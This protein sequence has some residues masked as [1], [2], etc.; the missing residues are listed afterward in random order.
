MNKNHRNEDGSYTWYITDEKGHSVPVTIPAGPLAD[1]ME[2]IDTRSN[3][4]D[5][6]WN[7]LIDWEFY[8]EAKEGEDSDGNMGISVNPMDA[9]VNPGQSVEEQVIGV[10]VV[11]SVAVVETRKAVSTLNQKL[12]D[13]YE[14][15]YETDWTQ[16]DAAK[17]LGKKRSTIAMREKSIQQIVKEQLGQ[18]GIDETIIVKKLREQGHQDQN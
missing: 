14:K 11:E 16:E 6:T 3:S 4:S 12:T 8:K 15:R 10:T 17:A 7:H 2:G 13:T 1:G 5:Y 9:F 18:S